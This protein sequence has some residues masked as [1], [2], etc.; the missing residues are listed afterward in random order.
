MA[1]TSYW[2]AWHRRKTEDVP[3]RTRGSDLDHRQ[4]LPIL[5]VKPRRILS[6]GYCSGRLEIVPETDGGRMACRHRNAPSGGFPVPAKLF[7]RYPY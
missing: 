6:A 7:Y 1:F 2:T 3:A 4:A 5:E